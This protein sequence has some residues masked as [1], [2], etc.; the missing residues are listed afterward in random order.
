MPEKMLV[1]TD[2]S[3]LCLNA[4][5]FAISLASRSHS[6]I[7]A[8][9]VID[10]IR[11]V[12][13]PGYSAL[14]GF[15]SQLMES[16]NKSGRG[17]LEQIAEMCKDSGVPCETIMAEGDPADQILK[18]SEGFDILVIGGRGKGGLE[19][20][21]LGSTAGRIVRHSRVPVIVVPNDFDF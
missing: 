7:T 18:I 12:H 15:G 19:R 5:E 6:K 1:A 4:A 21:I 14:P 10:M 9:Y 20:Q 16:M 11:L 3:E 17:A 13:I 8:I 2:G